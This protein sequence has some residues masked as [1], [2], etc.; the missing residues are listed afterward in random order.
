MQQIEDE[1]LA[2]KLRAKVMRF[3]A[4][5]PV[6]PALITATLVVVPEVLGALRL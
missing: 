4:S 2:L 6:V 3:N 5:A 1:T